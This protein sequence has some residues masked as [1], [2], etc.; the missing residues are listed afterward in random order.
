[1]LCFSFLFS[2]ALAGTL[3]VDTSVFAG[4]DTFAPSM[5]VYGQASIGEGPFGLFAFGLAAPGWGEVYSGAT[6]APVDWLAV[7]AGVGLE[8]IPDA[9]WRVGGD[10]WLGSGRWSLLAIGELGGSGP[11]YKLVGGYAATDWLTLGA[12]FEAQHGGGPRVEVHGDHV[13]VY[14]AV[15]WG[16]SGVSLGDSWVPLGHAGAVIKF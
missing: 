10:I 12:M 8:T 3:K 13:T 15:L 6:Y 5:T 16:G 2:V 9:P 1:M 4:E 14:G 7:E 11:W